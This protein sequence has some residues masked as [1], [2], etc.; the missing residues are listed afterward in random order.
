[1]IRDVHN[2]SQKL[3]WIVI[4][5]CIGQDSVEISIAYYK[6]LSLLWQISQD[7]LRKIFINLN[8]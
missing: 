1:M 3:P 8:S 6:G 7:C 4:N 5:I 2:L